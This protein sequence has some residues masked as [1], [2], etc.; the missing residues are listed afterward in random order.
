MQVKTALGPTSFPVNRTLRVLK[1]RNARGTG[2][3]IAFTF[4]ATS[5]TYGEHGIIEKTT[6]ARAAHDADADEE[7]TA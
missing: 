5:V 4:H 7:M 2:S 3:R 6:K 1:A